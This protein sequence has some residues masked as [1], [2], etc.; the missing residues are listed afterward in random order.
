MGFQSKHIQSK[1]FAPVDRKIWSRTLNFV[2]CRR[3]SIIFRIYIYVTLVL[4][5]S[6]TFQFYIG[7]HKN[8]WIAG[9]QIAVFI[10]S[11]ILLYRGK[12][13]W[14]KNLVLVFMNVTFFISSSSYGREVPSYLYTIPIVLGTLFFFKSNQVKY[15]IGLLILTFVNLLLLEYTDYSLFR[16]KVI[17]TASELKIRT[18]INLTISISLGAILMRE[19]IF[20]HR[21]NQ[22]RLKRLNLKLKRKNDKLKKINGELDSF[23]YRSSHDL[24]SP[25]TSIMGI[26][27]II[28]SE[29]DADKIQEY[30]TFQERSVKKLDTLIQD[31]LSIS[32]NSRMDVMV[33]PIYL[34]QF[35]ESCIESL[36]YMDEFGKVNIEVNIPES[37][38]C[39]S[40]ANRLTVVFNNLFS[41]ALR[42]YD[43]T[44]QHPFLKV[45]LVSPD[46]DR[47]QI[48]IRDN[49]IG[50]KK[51][52]LLKVFDMF[53]RATD[54]NNGSGLG[55]Y[56]VREAI[57]KVEGKI[58][59]NS[60]YGEGTSV[61]ITIVNLRLEDSVTNK[62]SGTL[63]VNPS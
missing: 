57:L 41:N 19:L 31:I 55:L 48:L 27:N 59:L 22:R 50:I 18:V 4:I 23:V 37:L 60:I 8:L 7:I 29:K 2:D 44:K 46:A 54:R 5:A 33:Q 6:N 15:A 62:L 43:H 39:Y 32:R 56:I 30:M 13:L 10:A 11:A 24:R 52:H 17:F 51:E 45:E 53:Y 36:S 38:V 58:E 3:D 12:D 28:K 20:M 34:K 21:Y 42:Y 61:L 14:S 9:F 25:L 63:F 40:D 49:G 26:I 1:L 16:S 47:A 35:V